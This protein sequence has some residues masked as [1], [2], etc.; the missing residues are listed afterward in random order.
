MS[1]D[2]TRDQEPTQ[3]VPPVGAQDDP[4]P[5]TGTDRPA[6]TPPERRS[7]ET[8]TSPQHDADPVAARLRVSTVVW[9][10]VVALVGVGVLAWSAGARIDVQLAVIVLLAV[11]GAALLV[12]SVV[13]A[14]RRARR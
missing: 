5:Q 10:L 9:G 14:G 11:A 7:H 2:D 12:G 3:V 13:T 8:V 4:P 1:T 6:T